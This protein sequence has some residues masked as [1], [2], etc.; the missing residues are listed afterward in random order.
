MAEALPTAILYKVNRIDLIIARPFIKSRFITLVNLLADA[1]IMPEYLTDR[2][3]SRELAGHV[4]R[5]LNDPSERQ[6]TTD[7]LAALR[8]RVAAP[9]TSERAAERIVSSLLGTR[10]APALRGPHARPLAVEAR[11][12][13]TSRGQ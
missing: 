11:L 3:V 7:A 4:L 5:W 2:E 13:S 1:E 10:P 9:G 8:D 12:A 6:R